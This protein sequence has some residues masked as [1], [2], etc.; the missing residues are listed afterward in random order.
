MQRSIALPGEA[1]NAL[2][3]LDEGLLQQILRVIAVAH[4]AHG[5]CHEP[6]R[7][8]VVERALR[9]TTSVLAALHDVILGHHTLSKR[10]L[11]PSTASLWVKKYNP[12][13]ELFYLSRIK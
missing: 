7:V 13:A 12:L 8:V 9:F 6:R 11:G 4:V 10:T 3:R 2:E 1:V 5:S